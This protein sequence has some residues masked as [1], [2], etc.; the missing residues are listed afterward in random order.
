MIHRLRIAERVRTG[1]GSDCG[2]RN[3]DCEM[4]VINEANR[5]SE[6]Q[7]PKSQIPNRMARSLPLAVLTTLI[8]PANRKRKNPVSK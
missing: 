6:I 4:D 1:S 5:K 8:S 3:S 2:L 7:N